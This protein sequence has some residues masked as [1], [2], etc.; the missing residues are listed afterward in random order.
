MRGLYNRSHVVARERAAL[1]AS[2]STGGTSPTFGQG[3]T[4]WL[5]LVII[6]ALAVG[7]GLMQAFHATTLEGGGSASSAISAATARLSF[8]RAIPL[9]EDPGAVSAQQATITGGSHAK[10]PS[11]VGDGAA[12][13][14]LLAQQRQVPALSAPAPVGIAAP[15]PAPPPLES[16]TPPGKVLCPP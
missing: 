4:R 2:Y 13:P 3:A 11:V 10:P 16:S 1:A 12:A 9:Q 14:P 5:L 8:L 15:P 7:A 6:M